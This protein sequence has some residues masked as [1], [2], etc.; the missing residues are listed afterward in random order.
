[1]KFDT[2][3][4]EKRLIEQGYI[5]SE[6]KEKKKFG[7][8]GR[9]KDK[10][11]LP[12]QTTLDIMPVKG[13][14]GRENFIRLENGFTDI[15]EL[16]GYNLAGSSDAEIWGILKQYETLVKLYVMPMKVLTLYTPLDTKKQ[17]NYYL[18]QAKKA[19]NP[20]HREILMNNYYEM[21]HF[22]QNNYNKEFYIQIFADTVQELREYRQDF[23]QYKGSLNIAEVPLKKKRAIFFRLNNP[24]TTVYYDEE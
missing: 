11:E 15:F 14:A 3:E 17:Q 21:L 20:I 22:E 4:Q 24:T 7:L 10:P 8:F 12:A 18:K 1:M 9:K 19:K 5:P 23:L 2:R 16:Q 13:L 6:N